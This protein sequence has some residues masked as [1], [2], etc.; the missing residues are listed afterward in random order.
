VYRDY[1]QPFTPALVAQ[2]RNLGQVCF[3]RF[4]ADGPKVN[5][6]RVPFYLLYSAFGVEPLGGIRKRWQSEVDR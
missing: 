2:F 5:E 3:C 6:C 1:T 4:R